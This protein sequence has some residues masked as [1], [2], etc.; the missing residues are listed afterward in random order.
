MHY[1]AVISRVLTN[2]DGEMRFPQ[3]KRESGLHTYKVLDQLP[4]DIAAF[5]LV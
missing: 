4:G 1:A 5:F 2:L 3:Y